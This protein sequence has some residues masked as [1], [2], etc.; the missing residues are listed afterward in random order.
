MAEDF[1]E[2]G[3]EHLMS[4]SQRTGCDK[5]QVNGGAVGGMICI[6]KEADSSQKENRLKT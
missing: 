6:E 1:D 4:S 5:L 3:F 2:S